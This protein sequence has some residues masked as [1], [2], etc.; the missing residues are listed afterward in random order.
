M[1]LPA[2]HRNRDVGSGSESSA[3]I[4][5]VRSVVASEELI[6]QLNSRLSPLTERFVDQRIV[7]AGDG[8]L[9]ADALTVTD[10]AHPPIRQ[11]I[12]P[13]EDSGITTFSYD[14][15]EQSE[16]RER[17]AFVL[18]QGVVPSQ[19]EVVAAKFYLIS[20]SF[21]D[22]Q[23]DTFDTPTGFTA[24]VKRDGTWQ[25]LSARQDLTW[26]RND[27]V[28]RISGWHQKKFEVI[29]IPALLFEEVKERR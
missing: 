14:A 21:R 9:F 6:L 5:T 12:A 24:L 19:A 13:L 29:E 1:T 20:G 27:S 23:V 17:A 15:V 8:E 25:S 7:A 11:Q 16:E 10:L 4:E 2:C 28:W 3:G 18:W 26:T 22:S